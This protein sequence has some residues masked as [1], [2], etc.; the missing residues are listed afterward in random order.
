MYYLTYCICSDEELKIDNQ[1]VRDNRRALITF[2][3]KNQ[4]SVETVL[5][6]DTLVPLNKVNLPL[7][8][9]MCKINLSGY[10]LDNF[11]TINP[12]GYTIVCR[13]GE[14]TNGLDYFPKGSKI[15]LNSGQQSKLLYNFEELVP[16]IA[17]DLGISEPAA[18]QKSVDFFSD[19]KVTVLP[20]G[21]QGAVYRFMQGIQNYAPMGYTTRAVSVLK[22]TGMTG[23]KIITQA[24]LTF[25]GATYIGAVFFGY[26]GSVAGNNPVGLVFN[27]T[28]YVLSRPMRGVEITL[29]G[30]ILGPLSNVIGLPLILNGTQEMLAGKGISIQEY[31]KIGI[32]FERIT[33]STI[34]KK[35]KKIYKI[36]RNKDV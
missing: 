32:A 3:S 9:P 10:S 31:T 24:P 2:F 21:P 17:Q 25:V 23:A 27:S 16:N 1:R 8:E 4:K 18:L 29:N 26:C 5:L 34:F 11:R 19:T 7:K 15:V 28:S 36:I 35:T 20:S 12:E 13:L 30:L 22:T 6:T 33:N 14:A